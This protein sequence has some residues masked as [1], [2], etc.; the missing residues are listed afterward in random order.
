MPFYS[1]SWD[2]RPCLM[3]KAGAALS[4]GDSQDGRRSPLPQEDEPERR[5]PSWT[6]KLL[7][8][9]EASRWAAFDLCEAPLKRRGGTRWVWGQL[10]LSH[11]RQKAKAQVDPAGSDK[12]ELS[13]RVFADGVRATW[14]RRSDTSR[15]TAES[16]KR[17]QRCVAGALG[18]CSVSGDVRGR[19]RVGRSS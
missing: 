12:P 7:E 9:V 16:L 14:P 10:R 5:S 13:R 18:V 2:F 4:L 19:R 15:V 8:P 1:L 6:T 17:S 11:S 3:A